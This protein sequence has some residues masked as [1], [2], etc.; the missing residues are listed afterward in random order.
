MTRELPL[1]VGVLLCAAFVVALGF[2]IVAPVVPGLARQLGA[3]LSAAAL[4]VS[5]FAIF[6]MLGAPLSGRMTALCG[7]RVQYAAGLLVLALATGACGQAGS[8]WQLVVLR[9]ISGIGSVLFTVAAASLLFQYTPD[10][11][12]GRVS[13]M[14]ATAYVLGTVCG[15]LVGGALLLAG[16]SAPFTGYAVLVVVTGLGVSALLPRPSGIARDRG[17]QRTLSTIVENATLRAALGANLAT[18]WT[19]FGI[20]MS[21]LPLFITEALQQPVAVVAAAFSLF[22]IGNGAVSYAAGRFADLRGRKPPI[23]AGLLLSCLATAALALVSTPA[24]VLVLALLAGV[25]TGMVSPPLHAVLADVTGGR[26]DGKV[27]ATFQAAADFGTI[28]GALAGGVLAD[29][30]GFSAAFLVAALFPAL[31]LLPWLGRHDSVDKR[32]SASV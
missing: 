19:A 4:A 22:A 18:G 14:F 23:V 1:A 21:L 31:A 15:P 2:G 32:A 7:A 9:A 16:P 30:A 20:R 13:G 28:L 24:G 10:H 12:R 5:V 11:L 27:I 3:D 8:Y 25:A 6:R 29:L 26:P 17:A